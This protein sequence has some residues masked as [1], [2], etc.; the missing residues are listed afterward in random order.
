MGKIKGIIKSEIVVIIAASA[1]II[2]A[3][4]IP[5]SLGYNFYFLIKA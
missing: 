4:F 3:F 5:P 2:S 1:A